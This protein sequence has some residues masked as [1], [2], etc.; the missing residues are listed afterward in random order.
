[1]IHF[2]RQSFKHAESLEF[3]TNHAEAVDFATVDLT[4]LQTDSIGGKNP[5]V[6]HVCRSAI[7]SETKF[8]I[9]PAKMK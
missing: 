4:S 7:S 1:M 2:N 3:L 9:L 5:P 6:Q 8:Q